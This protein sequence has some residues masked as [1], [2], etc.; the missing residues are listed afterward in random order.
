MRTRFREE[1]TTQ[2][3]AM[4]LQLRGGTMSHLKLIKLLYLLD[5]EALTRWGRPITHD[6]YYS[7]DNG[8]VLS[9]TLDRINGAGEED[10]YW[11]RFIGER[12][13][14]EVR[15]REDVERPSGQLSPAEEALIREV[16]EKHGRKS[17]WELVELS[18][19]L[20]EWQ[21]PHG[22]RLPIDHADILRNEGFSEEE[23][24]EIAAELEE[25]ALADIL[26]G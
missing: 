2:A 14:H 11:S 12:R 19:E 1:K 17:R 18:H 16:F 6:W 8:P 24:G 25:S 22:S 7:M 3:A 10:T 26:F 21:H 15:L 23:I 13:N 20:P 4:L 5:R 9:F